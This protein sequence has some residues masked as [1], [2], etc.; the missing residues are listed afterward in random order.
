M[1]SL[2]LIQSLMTTMAVW[3]LMVG[4]NGGSGIEIARGKC[5]FGSDA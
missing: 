1:W 4:L 3:C 2:L 5:C